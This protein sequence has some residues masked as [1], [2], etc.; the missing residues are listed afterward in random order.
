MEGRE[1]RVGLTHRRHSLVTESR[2]NPNALTSPTFD[3]NA[4]LGQAYG[5]R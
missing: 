5:S 1:S 3:P 2:G 4:I